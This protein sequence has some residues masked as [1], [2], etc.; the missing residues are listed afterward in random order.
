MDLCFV[1]RTDYIT[2]SEYPNGA[3]IF[4][5]KNIYTPSFSSFIDDFVFYGVDLL[6]E[7]PHGCVRYQYR[8]K[9]YKQ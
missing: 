3:K 8:D 7:I 6:L 5:I 2:H 9:K 4:E 1:D